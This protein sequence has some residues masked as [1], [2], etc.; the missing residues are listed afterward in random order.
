MIIQFPQRNRQ[1]L[2]RW[3]RCWKMLEALL[4]AN[5]VALILSLM[6]G[7][8]LQAIAHQLQANCILFCRKKHRKSLIPVFFLPKWLVVRWKKHTVWDNS[9]NMFAKPG[10]IS[11]ICETK[12]ISPSIPFGKRHESRLW[13][14]I[15]VIKWTKTTW[16]RC[17]CPVTNCL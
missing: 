10:L 11:W 7:R 9:F 13:T 5:Y 15:L 17:V 2:N 1:A 14:D 12:Q 6:N 8:K 3:S 16:F 4:Q